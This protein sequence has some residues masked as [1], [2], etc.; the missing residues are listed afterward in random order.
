M[1]IFHFTTLRLSIMLLYHTSLTSLYY[2][3]STSPSFD[4]T[5]ILSVCGWLCRLVMAAVPRSNP[6]S[7]SPAAHPPAAAASDAIHDGHD[8]ERHMYIAEKHVRG[9]FVRGQRVD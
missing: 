8:G 3:K 5:R 9:L 7:T 2:I 6:M 1:M 4:V